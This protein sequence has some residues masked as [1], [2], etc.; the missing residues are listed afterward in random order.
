M[1]FFKSSLL[2]FI[3][4]AIALTGCGNSQEKSTK[5]SK[6]TFADIDKDGVPDS[7]DKDNS[8]P[9][10]A[11]VDDEGIAIDSDKDGIPDGIDKEIYSTIGSK[12][13]S[14][15]VAIDSD[16][17]GVPDGIDKDDNTPFGVKVDEDGVA[18]DSDK[19][20]VPDGIDKEE[21]TPFGAIVDVSGIAIDSDKD[22]VPDGID[23][24]ENTPFGAIVD[25][26]GIAIDSDKDGVPDGIDKDNNTPFGVK[27]D[28]DGLVADTDM[29]GIPDFIDAE[30][31]VHI[32]NTISTNG[33][34]FFIILNSLTDDNTYLSPIVKLQLVSAAKTAATNN[35]NIEV[36]IAIQS[37]KDKNEDMKLST[38]RMSTVKNFFL[39]NS[40][41]ESDLKISSKV[42]TISPDKKLEKIKV[43][44]SKK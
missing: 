22:G 3:I 40:I 9:F 15:G 8:T 19:D 24:E 36:I 12:V 25:V 20:G 41:T 16:K 14:D 32:N 37:K 33:R 1:K 34:Q 2:V 44:L 28:K 42:E 26:S 27:V 13:D 43:I 17:D 10:G 7:I 11:K 29:D 39:E 18:I 21:N 38:E 4:S 30:P 31:N 6:A 23:K 5:V 35:Y